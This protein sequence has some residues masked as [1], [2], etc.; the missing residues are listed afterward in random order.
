MPELPPAPKLLIDGV[1]TSASDGATYPIINPATGAEIGQA[2]DA[3]ADDVDRA[4]A[5][6]RRAFDETDWS[7]NHDLRVRCIRQLHQ[8]LV[9]HGDQMRALTTAEVGAPAFTTTGPQYD[10]P[11]EG[12]RWLADMVDGYAWESDLGVAEPM[13]I[14]TR[15]TVRKEAI[16]VVA[17]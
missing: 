4:I 12:L 11:V 13:G 7:T 17:A 2:P 9:E 14:P 15:R 8:A 10:V 16:G 1:L 6:A 3:T 5:A